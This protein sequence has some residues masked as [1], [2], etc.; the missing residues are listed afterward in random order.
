MKIPFFVGSYAG[1]EEESI[2]RYEMDLENGSLT[3]IWAY[4]GA[5]NPSFV[6][7]HPNGKILYSVE[8]LTPQGRVTAYEIR[9]GGLKKLASLPSGG[10]D[11]CH[12]ALDDQAQYL[13]VSNYTGGSLAVFRLDES[14]MLAGMTDL[15][16]HTGHGTYEIRQASSHVHFS[17][18]APDGVLYS[19]DLGE[20]TVYVYRL[21]RENGKL[22]ETDGNISIPEGCGPRHL[23]F[24]EAVG[25]LAVITEMGASLVVCRKDGGS[26]MA[27]DIISALPDHTDI[28]A[29]KSGTFRAIGAAI[30]MT[31]RGTILTSQRGHDSISVFARNA[32]GRWERKGN[33]PSGGCTPRDFT[34]F[35]KYIVAANQDSDRI[36]VLRFDEENAEITDTGMFEEILKPVC[37]MG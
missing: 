13:F 37:V 36:C 21:D 22:V 3:R 4:A 25:E 20:D 5:E 14:G 27:A 15:K 17:K 6:L 2:Y 33:F 35:G 16:Q 9:Q 31:E 18:Y 23:L 11:P 30:Q 26:Y 32:N 12:L 28:A 24:D 19:C 7:P 8:E 29:L 1:A 10:A 34:V